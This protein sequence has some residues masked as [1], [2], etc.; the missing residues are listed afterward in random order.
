MK[1]K[2]IGFILS[3]V[4]ILTGCN[5]ASSEI[6]EEG[7]ST[8]DY[9][10]TLN[11]S[12]HDPPKGMR[13]EFLQEYWFPAIEEETDGK[14]Q[15]NPVFGG[16]LLTSTEALDGVREGVADIGLVY[17]DN[18]AQRMFSYEL[19]KLF[20]VAPDNFEGMYQIFDTAM[21]ELPQFSE[22]LEKNNQKP[23][24]ITTGLPIVF[25]ST[26]ELA[27]MEAVQGEDWRASSRWYL[28]AM[29]NMGANPVSVPWED[30]YMSLETGVI[31]GVMTN[32][33]GFHMMGFYET[34]DNIIVGTELW[35]SA[36]FIHTI[37]QDMWDSLPIDIQ[38]GILK[39]TEQA[40]EEFANVYQ[41]ELENTIQ[42]Q[43]DAGANVKIAD[44]EDVAAFNDQELFES[45]RN[46]W[47]EEAENDHGIE[48]ADEYVEAMKDIM[49]DALGY[50][51]YE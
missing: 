19:L 10:I 42:E 15:I 34:S 29:R 51:E 33:D 48:N 9:S 30:V 5:T 7:Y 37:N 38:E 12:D 32:Y 11:Y 45:M 43:R 24:L 6:D 27:S 47:A 17:P 40:Q 1:F 4:F 2:L 44:D 49:N 36:P 14:V 16:G 23:L 3:A 28:E 18:F 39:A 22:D 41:Q 8:E 20:P 26:N 25:G 21:T 50:E 13:T 35:W 31:D 46:T